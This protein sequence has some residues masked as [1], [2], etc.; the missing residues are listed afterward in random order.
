MELLYLHAIAGQPFWTLLTAI[1]FLILIL[2]AGADMMVTAAV[3]ISRRWG[4]PQGVVGATIVSLGTTFPECAVSVAAAVQG[5]PDVALGNAV[6]SIICDTGLILG[7]AN[8]MAPLPLER[9]VVGR[10]GWIQLGAGLLLVAAC[11]PFATPAAALQT[12]GVLPR[13]MGFVFLA[14]LGVYIGFSIRWARQTN[15]AAEARETAPGGGSGHALWRLI[16]GAV[17]VV[18]SSKLLIPL[19]SEIALRLSVPQSIV[20]ATIVAFGTSLPELVT[21]VTAVRKGHGALAVGNVIG[22][23]ILNVLFVAGAAAAVT[24]GGLV[25]PAHFFRLLFPAMLIILAVFRVGVLGS[26]SHLK[27]PF[28]PVLLAV[29]A[30]VTLVSY[31]GDIALH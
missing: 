20:G 13:A 15:D 7:L 25:A 16:G 18:V 19:V 2:G 23:D 28:G 26:R 22:A 12:G 11:F 6:G 29:Y 27:R 17:M 24:P 30:A 21:A 10:Q 5:A 3:S 31:H 4:V 1:A 9:Q 14:L 8:C